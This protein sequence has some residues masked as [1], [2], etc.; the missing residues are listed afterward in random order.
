M[1]LLNFYRG[2]E[3]INNNKCIFIP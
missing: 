1:L 3:Y 2:N